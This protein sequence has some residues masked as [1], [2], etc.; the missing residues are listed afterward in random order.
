MEHASMKKLLR[1]LALVFIGTLLPAQNA[2][3]I[4][5][6]NLRSDP[7]RD[8]PPIEKL[9]PTAQVTLL[10]LDPINGYYHVTAPDGQHGWIWRKNLRISQVRRRQAV[11]YPQ[12]IPQTGITGLA[13]SIDF[14]PDGRFLAASS[15]HRVSLFEREHKWMIRVFCCHSAGI[16]AV[17]F[18]RTGKLL[19]SGSS[20]GELAI[21]DVETGAL[22]KIRS[23]NT[24]AITGI[25]YTATGKILTVG[26]DNA[27]R[28]WDD[29]ECKHSCVLAQT[30]ETPESLAVSLAVSMNDKWIA[31]GDSANT[32]T[33]WQLEI[34]TRSL[35]PYHSLAMPDKR[36]DGADFV[37]G[38][39]FD[40]SGNLAAANFG[41]AVVLQDVA[42]WVP[43][44]QQHTGLR[45]DGLAFAPDGSRI[46]VAGVD[47]M[48][49]GRIL[50]FNS[51]DGDR[52]FLAEL[53]AHVSTL[54]NAYRSLAITRDGKGMVA[55]GEYLL[56]WDLSKNGPPEL[57]G[58]AVRVLPGT[59]FSPKVDSIILPLQRIHF[60]SV[61]RGHFETLPRPGMAN[62]T[63]ALPFG[64][65]AMST[66]G[67]YAATPGISG[68]FVRFIQENC[69]TVRP[70]Q[71]AECAQNLMQGKNLPPMMSVAVFSGSDLSFIGELEMDMDEDPSPQFS[72]DGELLLWRTKTGL[73]AVDTGCMCNKRRYGSPL[74][75]EGFFDLA[76]D[77]STSLI[78]MPQPATHGKVIQL[79]RLEN[80]SVVSTLTLE[81][82]DSVRRLTFNS[83]RSDEMRI[84][85]VGTTSGNV[86]L[87][88]PK[89]GVVETIRGSSAVTS[90][91]F[92][93]DGESLA[94]GRENGGLSMLSLTTKNL[95]EVGNA[96]AGA[97]EDVRFGFGGRWISSLSLDAI[98]FWDS[99]DLSKVGTLIFPL[100]GE[101]LSWLFVD[102]RGL[103]EGE[104]RALGSM[105]WRFSPRLMDVGPVELFEREY[106]CQGL[107][108]S[109]L[110]GQAAEG[111]PVCR[112][113]AITSRSR[114][115]PELSIAVDIKD[116]SQPVR[117]STVSVNIHLKRAVI[118]SGNMEEV[119][120][121]RLFRGGILVK[122]WHG[123]IP[124]SVNDL[125]IDVP[126][127]TGLNEFTAYAFNSDN[128]KSLDAKDGVLGDYS[129]AKPGTT[130][131]FSVGVDDYS[132]G[133]PPLHYAAND[134]KAFTDAIT[135][136]QADH[137]V[138]GV[139]LVDAEATRDN[140]LCGL[141]R[142]ANKD[143]QAPL[144]ALA[145]LNN[146]RPTNIEDSVYIFFSGHGS[147][148]TRGFDLLPMDAVYSSHISAQRYSRLRNI[149]SDSDLERLLEPIRAAQ[150]VLVLDACSAGSLITGAESSSG[151]LNLNGFAQMAREKGIYILAGAT[152][153]Q[154]A[155]EGPRQGPGSAR[156]IMSYVLVEE[157]LVQGKAL[158]MLS[159]GSVRIEDWFSYAV[160]HVP[161]AADQ[162]PVAFLP[163][164][165]EDSQSGVLGYFRKQ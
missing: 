33:V 106:F 16:E 64:K 125:H 127:T 97:V 69:A 71:R 36:P 9:K 116:K 46:Y 53:P 47:N 63:V 5:N 83:G 27:L 42:S 95:S 1:L 15:D 62:L 70:D 139:T 91:A 114:H 128:V 126:I 100:K 30:S 115:L 108:R 157:G 147:T 22:L 4:G 43:V 57:F 133:I 161:S 10:E 59:I 118:G 140:I 32:V 24:S 90:L 23:V 73:F 138:Y 52:I 65:T 131:I 80:N 120:D 129:L 14:S 49:Q 124:R 56:Q 156:S 152:A 121:V 28:I 38:L 34:S 68:A 163:M 143:Q 103:F 113:P 77:A 141:R 107:M 51:K 58:E 104:S 153:R 45:L 144:C 50:S 150:E 154:A 160:G 11:R 29:G 12:P 84:L 98:Q 40:Q 155:M 66:D 130:Y 79:L 148:E 164:R 146:L 60:F 149:I 2:A 21:W 26:W 25:R 145:K 86:V 142:L 74:P 132:K 94:I 112:P 39:A 82:S 35:Q 76:M 151:P 165:R 123:E 101:T 137:L 72:Q 99:H 19:A 162:Q 119:R 110:L 159:G 117:A 20:N 89:A 31:V 135:T 3:V 78:A 87:W 7:S 81:G 8:N 44:F 54:I 55:G 13:K 93:S 105:L 48:S 96:H 109:V 6:T 61:L 102:P 37:R 158:A 111:Q 136:V 75:D 41:G 18:S 17:A 88:Q 92:S 122:H 134:A 85:A 67:R